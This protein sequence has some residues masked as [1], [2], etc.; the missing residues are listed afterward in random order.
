MDNRNYPFT[1]NSSLL[2]S[3]TYR[4]DPSW[5]LGCILRPNCG[6]FNYAYI[7][8]INNRK[9]YITAD[10]GEL[11]CVVSFDAS[12]RGGYILGTAV[13]NGEDCG[14]ICCDTGMDKLVAGRHIL[15]RDAFVFCP[16]VL[17]PRPNSE[18]ATTNISV[19]YTAERSAAHSEDIPS[20]GETGLDRYP[21]NW[22]VINGNTVG[23]SDAGVAIIPAP[24][25]GIR[26]FRE[27]GKIIVGAR[28][29]V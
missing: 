8:S 10:T 13:R 12:D 15:D 27:D 6:D 22:L 28:K 7:S 18:K 4:L 23:G 16:S 11:L 29:D 17:R 20:F 1:P 25:G 3:G 9:M 5:V 14:Y 24:G 21:I 19:A 26:I 2:I